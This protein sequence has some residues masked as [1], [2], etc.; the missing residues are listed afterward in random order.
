[1]DDGSWVPG[2][3]QAIHR[4]DGTWSGFVRYCERTNAAHLRWFDEG[5]YGG[6]SAAGRPP[7]P[8]V[9]RTDSLS[10]PGSVAGRRRRS[11]NRRAKLSSFLV[12]GDR[13]GAMIRPGR[14]IKTCEWFAV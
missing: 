5:G 4:A 7:R 8:A 13:H 11:D 14:E 12:D 10:G 6:S 1:M 3:L 2:T 9:S